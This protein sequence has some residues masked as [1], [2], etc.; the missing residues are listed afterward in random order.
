MSEREFHEDGCEAV[1]CRCPAAPDGYIAIDDIHCTCRAARVVK[2][3]AEVSRLREALENAADDG[4]H[5]MC[6]TM[7]LYRGCTCHQA[8]TLK[9]LGWA[10]P[11]CD[12][13]G[14]VLRADRV[15][16]R[17]GACDASGGYLIAAPK[18]G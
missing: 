8:A 4:H 5:A 13:E 1:T 3:T 18:G 12:G 17:C 14:A 11:A 16:M 9:A 10:C 2:L 15:R 6:E 7:R